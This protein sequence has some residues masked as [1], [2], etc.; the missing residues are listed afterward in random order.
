MKKQGKRG[1]DKQK[2]KPRIYPPTVKIELKVPDDVARWIR[3][4]NR[5]S[6][7]IIDLVRRQ[8]EI[9]QIEVNM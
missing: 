4:S 5:P 9:E 7:R 3:D 8:L 2:R 1:P 6:K